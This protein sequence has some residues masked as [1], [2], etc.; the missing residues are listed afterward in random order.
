MGDSILYPVC[1]I[2]DSE[3][4]NDAKQQN[5]AVTGKKSFLIYN[6]MYMF[7]Y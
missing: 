4:K 2:P 7:F 3:I 1:D 6:V 5:A